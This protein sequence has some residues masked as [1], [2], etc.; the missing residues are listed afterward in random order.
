MGGNT[1]LIRGVGLAGLCALVING[2]IG[3]GIFALPYA[4]AQRAG[5]WTPLIILAIG[6]ALLPLVFTLS[7]LSQMFDETGGPILYAEEAFGRTPGFAVGWLQFLS[8]AASTAANANALADYLLGST[9]GG[10]SETVHAVGTLAFLLLVLGLNFMPSRHTARFLLLASFAKLLPLLAIAALAMPH[11]AGAIA[12][13]AAAET[14]DPG[15]AV[16]LACYAMIGFEGMLTMAGEARNPKRDMPRALVSM[17]LVCTLVYALVAAAYVAT[18]YTPGTVDSAPV[19]S[20]GTAMLGPVGGMVALFAAAA[21]I[22]GNLVLVVLGNSRR[23]FAM[24][25]QGD[26]PT[27]FGA[28][29]E[30]SGIPGNAVL[31]VGVFVIA[32]ALSGGFV[33]LA[34]LSVAARLVVYLACAFA[35]PV[36]R[37]RRGL[38][39]TAAEKLAVGLSITLCSWLVLQSSLENW[40]G[41]AIA[42]AGGLALRRFTRR[43]AAEPA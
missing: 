36:I 16:L 28:V 5:G 17:F 35:L 3:A 23:L 12:N 13:P 4:L 14:W 10:T 30:D 41:L 32:L 15:K 8:V 43:A 38:E 25:Q 24:Q 6:V 20:L 26:L 21:S 18:A 33:V 9:A 29:R 22:L 39:T 27:W 11:L 42:L 37:K 40:V 19:A 1:G 2:V 31:A 7:R 34:V